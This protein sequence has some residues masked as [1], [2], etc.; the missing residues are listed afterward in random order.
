MPPSLESGRGAEKACRHEEMEMVVTKRLER[1]FVHSPQEQDEV[2]KNAQIFLELLPS[3]IEEGLADKFVVM[4]G[5][6]VIRALGTFEDAVILGETLFPNDCFSV[7]EV[8][9]QALDLGS[10]SY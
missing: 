3:L 6:K 4:K 2:D 7:Q 1:A 5:G 10:Y 8:T 9:R